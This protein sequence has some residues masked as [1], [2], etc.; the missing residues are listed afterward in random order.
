MI[1][2]LNLN[3]FSK[4]NLNNTVNPSQA[5]SKNK[6]NPD[7]YSLNTDTVSFGNNKHANETQDVNK[8]AELFYARKKL[9]AYANDLLKNELQLKPDQPLKITSE[10]KFLPFV[11]ILVDQAY[12]MGSGPVIVELNEPRINYLNK[13]FGK[14]PNIDWK[15]MRDKDLKE[16]GAAFV[17]FNMENSPYRSA[18]LTPQEMKTVC[19]LR[20]VNIP[21]AVA[22]KLKIDPKDVIENM[23]GLRK[24]QPLLIC[25]ER[26]HRPN[27]YRLMKYALE[28]GSGP[29]EVVFTEPGSRL[30]KS[31]YKHA[32]EDLLTDVPEWQVNKIKKWYEMG[33]AKLFL[34]GEDPNALEGVN[35][36]RV[37]KN[38]KARSLTFKPIREKYED[39]YPWTILYA[40][41]TM[42][43]VAAYPT[44]KDPLEA[45]AMAA[46]DVSEILR[47]GKF[48]E[49]AMELER[50]A[51]VVNDLDLKEIHFVSIDPVSKEPDGKTDLYVGLS[52]KIKFRSAYDK[53]IEGQQF[54]ANVPT[55]EVFSCPDKTKTRG[56]VS[57]TLPLSLNG[58]LIEGIKMDFQD[59]KVISVSA[60]TNEK[61]IQEH[62]K[63][64][65]GAS[66][67]GEVALVADSPIRKISER[68]GGVFNST[69]LDENAVCHI[70]VGRGFNTNIVGYSDIKDE[71]ER[72][73][74]LEES[75]IND[76]AIHTDFMIGGP[77]VIVEGIKQ[78]GEKVILIKDDKFQI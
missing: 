16:K 24:N 61:I 26:E 37:S 64:D 8:K 65:E 21:D 9:I 20:K 5:M 30:S 18:N 43:S 22:E 1:N 45:L 7:K 35:S 25:A 53:T 13:L 72:K 41:T 29:V 76:S 46:D 23:L 63:T 12:K 38:L 34:E 36:D 4:L 19:N 78:N 55:E 74:L 44:A 70:A 32:K 50:R 39:T 17:E 69:L 49:H 73:A 59:G 75:K 15:T 2:L 66:M 10:R 56:I 48:G 6:Q 51:N 47:K 52:P 67:L 14:Q 60:E 77:N 40:P 31:F 71:D 11:E 3:T 58:N 57:S 33:T 28:N 27:A 42:S 54:I 62:I 68:K